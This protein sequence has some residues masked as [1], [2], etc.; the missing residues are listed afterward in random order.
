MTR[1]ERKI[2]QQAADIIQNELSHGRDVYIRDLGK[3]TTRVVTCVENPPW[4]KGDKQK[5]QQVIPQF[6]AAPGLKE[7]VWQ[8][9]Y[10]SD[11]EMKAAG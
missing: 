8:R 6:K 7:A 4:I 3:F 2:L 1:S 11:R 9:H 5:F 10:L